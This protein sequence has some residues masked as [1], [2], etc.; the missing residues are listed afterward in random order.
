MAIR[1]LRFLFLAS[2][3]DFVRANDQ[4]RTEVNIQGVALKRSVFKSLK[5]GQWRLL[6]FAMSNV[7][8]R[9]RAKAI[10]TTENTKYVN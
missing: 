1:N 4:C 6:I 3:M 7:E 10:T 9:S 5:A 2:T 8:K